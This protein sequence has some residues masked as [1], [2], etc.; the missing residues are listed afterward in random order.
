MSETAKKS[1]KKQRKLQQLLKNS[2]KA[3]DS[4]QVEKVFVVHGL[5]WKMRILNDAESNWANKYIIPGSILSITSS[6]KAPTLAI[7]IRAIGDI[8]TLDEELAPIREFFKEEWETLTKDSPIVRTHPDAE[9][10]YMAEELFR[11][12]SERGPKYVDEL[13]DKWLQLEKEHDETTEN[14]KNSSGEEAKESKDSTDSLPKNT[15]PPSDQ[16]ELDS[17]TSSSSTPNPESQDSALQVE[18]KNV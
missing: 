2:A 11:F 10:H 15:T 1:Y 13:W 3:L 17:K 8:D 6:Q 16:L 12:L 4:G 7:G 9:K 14:L 5:K 18:I